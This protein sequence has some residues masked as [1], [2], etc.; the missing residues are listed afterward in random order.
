MGMKENEMSYTKI[1][2]IEI[3]IGERQSRTP[4]STSLLIHGEDHSSLIDCGAGYEAFR[5]ILN[6]HNI[7]DVYLTH[8]HL[9][10]IWGAI[11]FKNARILGNSYD[12]DKLQNLYELAKAN[13]IY[14]AL[15]E[16]DGKRW[17][18]H[19]ASIKLTA[20]EAM[21]FPVWNTSLGLTKDTYPYDTPIEMAGVKTIMVHSP[22]H[23]EGFC[24][25]Y[26]PDYGILHVGDID[27]TS[28]GPW[29][30]NSDSDIDQFITSAKNTLEFDAS[31]YVTS[32]QKGLIPAAEYKS[33]LADYLSIIDRREEIV[34]KAIKQGMAP[35]QLVYQEV[36][37]FRKNHEENEQHL[38]FEKVGIAKHIQRLIKHGEPFQDY[39]KHYIESLNMHEQYIN[40]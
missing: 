30:N 12:Y 27:L 5:Y 26:F 19:Q 13:G 32:H 16:E 28:F 23:C 3:I 7:K 15:G 4:F 9:D 2:P 20:D 36:F 33:K 21:K 11:N 38:L 39:Y 37:Y 17:V 35:D 40:Y 10:H 24:C 29:Y 8:Y 1:G 31:Y 6:G 22:G 34:K 14:A 25:P 18:D